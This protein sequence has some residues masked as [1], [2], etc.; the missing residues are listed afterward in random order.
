M[1]DA[2]TRLAELVRRLDAFMSEPTLIQLTNAIKD[3]RLSLNDVAAYV[4]ESSRTYH[5]AMVVRR[6]H[7]ELLVLTWLPGQGSVPHDHSGSV[8]AMVVL[9]GEA[10][11]TSWRISDDGYVDQEFETVIGKGELTAWQDAGV[12]SVRNNLPDKTLVT[13]HVYSP[14]L[15][16][17]RRF[18]ARPNNERVDV[19]NR[20]AQPTVV[21][22]GG[23]FSGSMT[24][25]QLLNQANLSRFPLHVILVERQGAIGEGVAYSTREPIHLLNVPAGKMS[26]WPEKPL[27]F[28]N[29]IRSRYGLHSV[30]DF[31]RRQW[32]GE[33]VRATLLKA[34]NEPGATAKLT[35]LFDEVRRISKRPDNGWMVSFAKSISAASDAVVIAIGH[36]PPTDPI[37]RKWSGKKFRFIADPWQ[38]FVANSILPDEP[39]VILGSSLTAIDTILSLANSPR[40]APITLISRRGLIPQVHASHPIPATNLDEMMQH[41]FQ[42]PFTINKLTKCVRDQID[43][44]TSSGGDWRSVIDG[45]RPHTAKIWRALPDIQRRRFLSHLRSF[46][47][48]HRHRTAVAVADRFES[49]KEQGLVKI[50]AGRVSAAQADENGVQMFVRERGDDRAIEIQTSWVINCTG[51]SASNSSESNPVIGSLLVH[52]LIQPDLLALGLKTNDDGIAYNAQNELTSNLY[53]AGTLRKPNSWES[54]AVPELRVQA[55]EIADSILSSF[56][57]ELSVNTGSSWSI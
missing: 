25:A 38:P 13:V 19:V 49:L 21:V 56:H 50:V 43:L 3:V 14:L 2:R 55:A 52:D 34:A 33:Y 10:V 46:W 53:I 51:P 31:V 16:E 18:N 39:V 15:E 35:V 6:E 7:Y 44:V 54:T 8:S 30:G 27:D 32:Y 17:F 12:H 41:L 47:E 40:T 36:R 5:R 48:V 4:K 37:G 22:V 20:P 24:A 11:E 42:Q 9:E 1:D 29:W 45:L 28:L 23:G 57:P 26:A